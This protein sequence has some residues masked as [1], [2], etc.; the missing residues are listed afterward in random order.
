MSC[1][2]T[3]G[4]EGAPLRSTFGSATLKGMKNP[5]FG[6]ILVGALIIGG[7]TMTHAA[8]IS[9]TAADDYTVLENA[10]AGDVVEIAPG[11]YKFR[12]Y[13]SNT[14]TETQPIII[15]AAPTPP[16]PRYGT[17]PDRT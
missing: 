14:G 13:L 2:H 1:A 9:M 15:R 3:K 11:T 7:K 10:S 5:C 6:W 16:I 8:T 4:G 17:W 12:V